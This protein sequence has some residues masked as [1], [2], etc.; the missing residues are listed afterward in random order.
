M[1]DTDVLLNNMKS[2]SPGYQTTFWSMTIYSDILHRSNI[3]LTHDLFTEF[4]LLT[5]L[6][7]V[8]LEH[9]LRVFHAD[10]GR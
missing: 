5:E 8:S 7:H 9:L 10:R 3:T 2:S 4:D 1:A 6:Q